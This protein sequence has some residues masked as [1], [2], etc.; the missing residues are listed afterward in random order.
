M[1][2]ITLLA[3]TVYSVVA[4]TLVMNLWKL[5]IETRELKRQGQTPLTGQ[6]IL[7][8]IVAALAEVTVVYLLLWLY[9]ALNT[10]FTLWTAPAMFLS[11]YI[12]R[13][14]VAYLATWGLWAF[15]VGRYRRKEIKKIEKDK[16][17]AL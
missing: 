14:P 11:I 12:F 1:N 15:F 10:P 5:V 17:G 13:Y 8:I 4:I 7:T 2:L 16:E 6:N 9:A 3:V